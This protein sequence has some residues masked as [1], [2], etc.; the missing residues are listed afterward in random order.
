MPDRSRRD[1]STRVTPPPRSFRSAWWLPGAHAQTIAGRFARPSEGIPLRRRR[2]ETPDGDFLDLDF[3]PDPGPD[4]P[5]IVVLHGLEGSSRRPYVAL[6]L[7]ELLAHGLAGVALNFRACSGEPNRLP[8]FYH[9]G[10]TGDLRFVLDHLGRRF[11]RRALGAAGASLGGNVVLRYL[12]EEGESAP[13][14]AAV[15]MSV[16]FDL[17]ACADRLSHGFGGRVYGRHF[18]RSL[19]AKVVAK[20][21]L[22]EGEVDVER[23]LAARNLI[24]Y[25]DALTAP[26][27]GFRDARDYYARADARRS[28]ADIRTPVLLLQAADDPFLR[29]GAVPEAVVDA[30]PSLTKAFARRGGHLGFVEGGAPWNPR[31]WAETEA[32]RFLSSVIRP[33]APRA[34]ADGRARPPC[35]RPGGPPQRPLPCRTPLG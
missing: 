33:G 1:A 20:R 34:H 9:S 10:D 2:I 27:H 24:E 14:A 35:A 32:A 3:G 4:R 18:L 11:P 6:L 8:R 30:N 23:V 16:P 25:D 12:G 21:R 13:L 7:R 17:S 31:F 28:L 19:K 29:P 15:A 22:L 5:L 26:L